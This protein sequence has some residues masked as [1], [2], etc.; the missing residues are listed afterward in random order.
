MSSC[1]CP[2]FCNSQKGFPLPSAA[3]QLVEVYLVGW[4]IPAFLKGTNSQVSSYQSIYI[5]YLSIYLISLSLSSTYL[6]H[7]SVCLST[8]LSVCLWWLRLSMHFAAADRK[9][10]M[11]MPWEK[12]LGPQHGFS[13]PQPQCAAV[14]HLLLGVRA[15][16]PKLSGNPLVSILI[17]WYQEAQI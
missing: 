16:S 7:L 8:C 1:Y 10:N 12:P 6:Y 14:T 4:L 2:C 15:P 11:L 3:S 13:C 9:A 17:G 5:Y